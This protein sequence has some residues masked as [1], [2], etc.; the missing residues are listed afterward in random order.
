[1]TTDDYAKKILNFLRLDMPL[2]ECD[3]VLGLG[4][5]DVRIGEEAAQLFLAGYGNLLVYSGGFGKITKLLNRQ[6]E[7][8]IFRDIAIKMGVPQ[9]KILTE[10]SATNTGENI[11]FTEKLLNKRQ[12]KVDSI[13][14]VTKPY[15][16][17]RVYAT[18]KKQ[19]AEQTTKVVVTSPKWSYEDHFNDD[20]PKDLF[21][22]V[23]VGDL[24][25]IQEFP[26]RGFQINQAIPVDVW[27]AYEFLV[28]QG[29]NKHLLA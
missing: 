16:E 27:K 23:M 24:Q 17:R 6:T 3:V 9:D 1:M 11:Q 8:E 4:T 13:L 18:F 29:Y 10:T 22:N 20:I 5:F 12:I 2:E 21:I 28:A 14:L 19:W 25:R 15:M 26:K 7:A